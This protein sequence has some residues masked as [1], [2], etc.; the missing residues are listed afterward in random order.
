[1]SASPLTARALPLRGE[2]R[3]R[4]AVGT[5]VQAGVCVAVPAVIAWLLGQPFVFPSLGPTVYL[6]LTAASTPAASP[7]NTLVGH[8]VSSASGYVALV[9]TGLTRVAPNLSHP[10]GRRVA[11]VAIAL[12]LTSA[13]MLLTD[14]THPPGGATTLIVAL[15]LLRTPWQ[16]LILMAAVTVTTAV[17]I[18]VNRLARRPY[19]LWAPALPVAL[20][21]DGTAPLPAG[22]PVGKRGRHPVRETAAREAAETLV[23]TMPTLLWPMARARITRLLAR[24]NAAREAELR[25]RLDLSRGTLM[26]TTCH[27]TEATRHAVADQWSLVFAAASRADAHVPALL[28]AFSDVFAHLLTTAVSPQARGARPR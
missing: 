15:G 4:H 9:V 28:H 5:A 6:A 13:G 19:P 18:A 24:G 22:R 1:M 12:A 26:S 11:A 21:P 3:G 17:L 16:L 10:D 23:A 20:P 25:R 8:L 7:R 27:D 14:T 2:G